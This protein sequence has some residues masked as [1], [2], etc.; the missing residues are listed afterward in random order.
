VSGYRNAAVGV[1]MNI[2][3]RSLTQ[4]ALTLMFVSTIWLTG[5]I[6]MPFMMTSMADNHNS[7]KPSPELVQSV[8]MLIQ[9]A[10]P[11]VAGITPPVKSL[12]IEKTL[13]YKDF[14]PERKF[15]SMLEDAFNHNSKIIIVNRKPLSGD[16][17]DTAYGDIDTS[18]T[19]ELILSAQMYRENDRV[20]LLL[21]LADSL[22][23]QSVWSRAFVETVAGASGTD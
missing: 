1:K 13:V 11:A 21:Q 3:A 4:I 17:R 6:M 23:A 2:T 12:R 20:T 22:S 7:G 9:E 18:K 15:R 8:K 10:V 19:K 16:N 14:F 5:C